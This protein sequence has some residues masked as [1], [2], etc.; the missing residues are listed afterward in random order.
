MVL[1]KVKN[2]PKKKRRGRPRL[3]K[4][5]KIKKIAICLLPE[6]LDIFNQ[7]KRRSRARTNQE[8][9]RSKLL[10]IEL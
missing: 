1:K 6:E 3:G 10:R 2:S 5:K 4:K 8:F 9:M 7:N